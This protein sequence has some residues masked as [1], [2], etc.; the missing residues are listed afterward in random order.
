M[1]YKTEIF[2][3]IEKEKV[4]S[5]RTC[6]NMPILPIGYT[7]GFEGI[8]AKLTHALFHPPENLTIWCEAKAIRDLPKSWE[9]LGAHE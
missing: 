8:I 6:I 4:Y 5:L 3:T 9:F 2:L 1:K 7:I